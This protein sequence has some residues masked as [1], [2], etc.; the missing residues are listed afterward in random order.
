MNFE[1]PVREMDDRNL[2]KKVTN[3]SWYIINSTAV[4]VYLKIEK[5]QQYGI[6]CFWTNRVASSSD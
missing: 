5:E 3:H 6:P 2:Q 1:S 4:I